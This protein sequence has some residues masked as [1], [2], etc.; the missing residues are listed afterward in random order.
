MRF[1]KEITRNIYLEINI[2]KVKTNLEI[3]RDV[4]NK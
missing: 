2:S 4:F 3:Y 1:N